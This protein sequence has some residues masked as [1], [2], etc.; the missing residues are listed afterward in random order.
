MLRWSC[1]SGDMSRLDISSATVGGEVVG[2]LAVVLPQCHSRTW[3]LTTTA[4]EMRKEGGWLQC[5]GSAG[6]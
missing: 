3:T 6:D 4:S 1:S 2:Q 5:S